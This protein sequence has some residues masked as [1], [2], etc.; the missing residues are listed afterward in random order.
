MGTDFLNDFEY[1]RTKQDHLACAREFTHELSEHESGADIEA[2]FGLI[3]D[4][5]FGV[6]KEGGSDQ[7]S[8]THSFGVGGD[9]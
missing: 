2:G 7:D 1:V 3:E 5:E 4:E 9:G 8:L 6:V